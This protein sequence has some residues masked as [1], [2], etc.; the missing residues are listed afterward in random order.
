MP[1]MSTSSIG[2]DSELHDYLLEVG[3]RESAVLRELREEMRDH[4]QGGM[5][6]SPEQ[7]ALMALLVR[8]TGVRRYL[9][10]GT[11][12]GYSSTAVAEALP[13]D[14]R[15]V[16]CDVSREWT[17]RARQAWER[18]GVADRI[19]LHLGPAAETLDRLLADGGAGTFDLAFI[20]ADK[21]GYDGYVERAL[22]LVRSGGLI[23]I[24]NVLWSGR[25]A[26]ASDNEESTVAIRA[27]N[28]KL[29]SDERVDL[30]IVPIGDGLTLLR[31]R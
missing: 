2:L 11:F 20:D 10:V 31:V 27:L 1:A 7:G 17:D 5:Q 18:A 8:L 16:C 22:Q 21:P 9:E 30:V 28:R 23:A 29:A 4:P 3:V 26:D 13:P 25:V 15:V 19:T 6:I 12:T 24:D 14:G